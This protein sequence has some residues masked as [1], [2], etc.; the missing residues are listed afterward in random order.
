MGKS[1]GGEF[2]ARISEGQIGESQRN[3]KMLE[4]NFRVF[5]LFLFEHRL[6]SKY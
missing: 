1:V 2:A 3:Q 4:S 5:L 6:L